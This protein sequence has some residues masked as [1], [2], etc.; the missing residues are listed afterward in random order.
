MT[1]IAIDVTIY[2]AIN[3]DFQSICDQKWHIWLTDLP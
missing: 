1:T 2:V 3:C